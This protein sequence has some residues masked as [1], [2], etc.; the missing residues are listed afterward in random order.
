MVLTGNEKGLVAYYKFDDSSGTWLY[1][2][3]GHDN[4]GKLHNMDNSNWVASSWPAGPK[5]NTTE[6]SNVGTTTAEVS[7]SISCEGVSPVTAKGVVWNTTKNPTLQDNLGYTDE[8]ADTT[9]F[10][11]K[12]TGLSDTTVYYVRAYATNNS[13]T[14]YGAVK[15]FTTLM[16][17]PMP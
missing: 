13:G 8:G 5:V 16:F 11:S 10:T 6:V 14:G 9:S 12:L 7:G 1:D 4:V 15:S 17:L 2:Y 3:S